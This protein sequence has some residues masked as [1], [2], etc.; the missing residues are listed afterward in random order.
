[1]KKLWILVLAI[2][3][4]HG[5][6]AYA[7]EQ[8]EEYNTSALGAYIDEDGKLV[9]IGILPHPESKTDDEK[10]EEEKDSDT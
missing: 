9:P 4:S 10:S 5:L 3:S 7:T 1:M 8:D 2:A 6:G